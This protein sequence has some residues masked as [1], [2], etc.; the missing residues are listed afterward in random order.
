M[1]KKQVVTFGEIMLRLSPQ[2]I[3]QPLVTTK[4]LNMGFAGAESTVAINLSFWETPAKFVTVLP[5][6]DLGYAARNNLREH[7]VDTSAINFQKGRMGT[8]YIEYGTSVRS[9]KVIYDRE[10]SAIALALLQDFD[11]DTIFKDAA[12]FFTSGITPALSESCTALCLTALKEA[13]AKG[14][15]TCFDLNFRRSLWSVEK[16]KQVYTSYLPYVDILIGNEGAARDVF[17]IKPITNGT[18][19]ENAVSVAKQLKVLHSNIQTVGMT[20]REQQSASRNRWSG[21][22]LHGDDIFNSQELD[23]E[24]YERLGA[25]DAFTAG[26]IYGVYHV[27]DWQ[28]TLDFAV[29]ASAIKHTVPGDLCTIPEKDILSVAG[30]NTAAHI[31][32]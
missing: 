32:R 18:K 4:E 12:F 9:S 2:R 29:A 13:K 17:Q 19:L 8:Y 22:I 6:Q 24:I 25:G 26:L 3:Y 16:A 14:M 5:N 27:W 20:I 10:Y 31:R 1:Q 21:L 23:V 11:W 15:T 30:G 7:G 28:Q